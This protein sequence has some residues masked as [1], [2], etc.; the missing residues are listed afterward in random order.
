MW[1]FL[2]VYS[3]KTVSAPVVFERD[4]KLAFS[5][6][7]RH[8]SA[9]WQLLSP[10]SLHRSTTSRHTVSGVMGTSVKC[11]SLLLRYTVRNIWKTPEDSNSL[12]GMHRIEVMISMKRTDMK[13]KIKGI[14]EWQFCHQSLTLRLSFTTDSDQRTI[15]SSERGREGAKP[16]QC[17]MLQVT[18]QMEHGSEVLQKEV[19]TRRLSLL[20]HLYK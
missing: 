7:P 1:H 3:V 10:G 18:W 8:T 12:R 15:N 4:V 13:V 16:L 5:P 6:E 9:R 2:E 11:W 14:G 19:P 17:V 20:I